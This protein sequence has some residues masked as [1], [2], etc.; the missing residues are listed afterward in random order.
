M[1]R[2]AAISPDVIALANMSR[3][4]ARRLSTPVSAGSGLQ[5][6]INAVAAGGVLELGDGT[7][8]GSYSSFSSFYINK[9][10]TIRAQIA[11]QAVLDGGGSR[12][13][14]EIQ[15]GRVVL[16]GLNITKGSAP[17]VSASPAHFSAPLK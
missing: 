10:I 12:R 9:T 16:E 14:F 17:D 8:T 6:A 13:V 5:A 1:Q 11:G 4:V 3:V 15:A 7:F 2:V